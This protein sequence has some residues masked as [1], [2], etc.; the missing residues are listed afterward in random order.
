MP[1]SNN[2]T[3]CGARQARCGDCSATWCL[4]CRVDGGTECPL[5]SPTALVRDVDAET[6]AR[7]ARVGELARRSRADGTRRVYASS[8]SAFERWCAAEGL[9]SLP[10]SHAVVALY[11][12]ELVELGRASSTLNVAL[13][14]IGRKHRDAREP[15]PTKGHPDLADVLEGA[16]RTLGDAPERQATPLLGDAFARACWAAP[17]GVAGLRDRALLSLGWFT[18]C[19]AGELAAL[20]VEDI[21]LEAR[22]LTVRIRR[23]KRD[24]RSEGRY[25]GVP[26][27]DDPAVNAARALQA[28][29]D[30]A[31]LRRGPLFRSVDRHGNSGAGALHPDSIARIVAR[32]VDRTGL[33]LAGVSSHSLRAGFATEAYR[34]GAQLER[35]R[36][37]LGHK[38]IE[39]TYRYIRKLEALAPTNPAWELVQLFAA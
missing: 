1:W 6:A 23:G 37:H 7:V 25:V 29:R 31:D 2:C 27:V 10:A 14:A 4:A 22:G 5:C 11:V 34:Q 13:A 38:R 9:P 8:W 17:S 32:A 18:A 16:R 33:E 19:R 20:R 24:Q 21:E 26:D 35:I 30:A 39:T 36:K 3:V 15:D 28:W 12:A